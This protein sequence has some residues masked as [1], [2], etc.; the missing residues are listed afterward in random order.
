MLRL[1]T[2]ELAALERATRILLTPLSYESGEA[3]RLASC[4]AVETLL[5]ASASSF[6][7]PFPGEVYFAGSPDVVRALQAVNPPPEW[8][9]HALTVHRRELGVNVA[10]WTEL[11]DADAVR[12]TPFYNDVVRP[13]RLLAPLVLM[14]DVR[15]G[16]LPAVLTVY[17][18]SEDSQAP[19]AA[20][21]K[22][23]AQ[24]LVPA[25]ASGVRACLGFARNRD[26]FGSLVE[27]APMG[28]VVLDVA[29]RVIHE[30]P[31]FSCMMSSDLEHGR[32]RAEVARVAVSVAGV[33]ARNHST[34]GVP[35]PG[36]SQLRT[37]IARYQISAVLIE[38]EWAGKGPTVIAIV[39]P[40]NP[41]PSQA[42]EIASRFGLTSREAE[43][44]QLLQK[45][46]SSREIA[47]A[48]RISVNTAR[49]HAERVLGKLGVHSRI[50]AASTLA[51]N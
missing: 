34:N 36:A 28:V 24:L 10:D 30:N 4:S 11:F 42:H 21:R 22:Q 31:F 41:G 38:D 3:W 43:V 9:R 40:M 19:R 15:P 51:G 48:L 49:R 5:N 47:V 1:S 27:S 14:T 39:A 35:R 18:D 25:F 45:G 2:G 26:T 20:R 16:E 7:F 13:Q 50:A 37:A 46:C 12:R 6:A 32:V 23:I 8:V 29:G 17:Y 33:G 44:A